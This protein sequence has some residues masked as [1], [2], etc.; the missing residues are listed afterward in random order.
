MQT[1]LYNK[2]Q[3]PKECYIEPQGCSQKEVISY[4][5][6]N[7]L[8]GI[9]FVHGKAGSGKSYLVREIAS[10]INGCIVLTPTNLAASL[11]S[12]ASTIHSFFHSALDNLDEGFQDPENL[13]NINSLKIAQVRNRLTGV[14]MLIFDEISMV[15]A[16]LMEMINVI[17]Q[18]AL[19][20]SKPFGGI[21][22]VLVGDM[23]QLPPIV[24]DEAVYKYL[25]Q[26]YGGIYFFNSHVIQREIGSIKLLELTES[27]RQNRDSDFCDVLDM[28]RKPMTAEDKI[29]ILNIINSRVTDQLPEDAIY[30]ASSNAQVQAVNTHKLNQLKGHINSIEAEYT[31][32]LQDRNDTVTLHHGD[33]PTKR[34]IREI[35][36][37]SAYESVLSF[38]IGAKVM[39][40]KSS[41]YWGFSNGDFGII[42]NFDGNSFL[43]RLDNGDSV[44]CPHP[45]DRF[46]TNLITDYRYDMEFDE[47]KHKLTRIT[48]FVQKTKQFPIKLAYAFTI[49]KSQGQTYEKVIIDL[50]S[51][52]FAPGQLYVALSRVKSLNG[53]YLTKPVSYS[54]IISDDSIF[55]FLSQIRKFNNNYTYSSEVVSKGKTESINNFVCDNFQ[56]F[57]QQ[58]EKSDSSEKLITNALNAYKV[59]LHHQE[60]EKAFW[61][62][63]K[64]VDLVTDVYQTDDYTDI[65]NCIKEQNYS[66]DGCQN[67]L[68]SI[69]EIYTDVVKLPLRQY[70]IDNDKTITFNI[71]QH[72]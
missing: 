31:I 27:F 66:K 72:A 7:N 14:R 13:Q 11:Y 22:V 41:K 1:N 28:F 20:S 61:E 12:R 30:I 63:Q 5:T 35:I 26:I 57:V 49:H 34:N 9:T 23:F 50:N 56:C 47:S 60:F 53:L 40:T 39:F 19:E 10:K 38:K 2:N 6:R 67:A 52:I 18:K 70:K 17:C 48:P 4:L 29:R 8:E 59:M 36:V 43:I 3:Y 58:N 44:L 55:V 25:L 46:K 51:H 33:L 71:E 37:P 62:L 65:V 42:E 24:S 15:R 16:D 64:V 54:D 69:F 68:N 45:D 32:K 21:P